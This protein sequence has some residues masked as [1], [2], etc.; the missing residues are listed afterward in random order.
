MLNAG[1]EEEEEEGNN[2]PSLYAL[3]SFSVE[4]KI[5]LLKISMEWSEFVYFPLRFFF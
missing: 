2:S 3:S 4:V 5:L 1:I